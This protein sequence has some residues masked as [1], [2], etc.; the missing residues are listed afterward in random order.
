MTGLFALNDLNSN[1]EKQGITLNLSEVKGPV[2]DR[3]ARSGLLR[4]KL[5]GR[6]YL[7]TA[8]AFRSLA[9]EN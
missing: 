3:L 9:Q 2:M 8:Q 5:S 4:H 7:S 1:L 6:V